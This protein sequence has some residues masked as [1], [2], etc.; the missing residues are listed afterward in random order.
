MNIAFV[1]AQE[2]LTEATMLLHLHADALTALTVDAS[3][4]AVG[5]VLEQFVDDSWKPLAFFSRHL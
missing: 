5:G 3:D 4:P 1:K 2:A